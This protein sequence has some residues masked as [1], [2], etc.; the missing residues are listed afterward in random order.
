ML[1]LVH[2]L[3]LYYDIY[4]LCGN[5]AYILTLTIDKD[6]LYCCLIIVLQ[7][8]VS[9][10]GETLANASPTFTYDLIQAVNY[11]GPSKDFA[12]MLIRSLAMQTVTQVMCDYIRY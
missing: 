4:F 8:F 1:L 2:S 12:I 10:M 3:L 11:Y 5:N 9:S 6:A 7:A